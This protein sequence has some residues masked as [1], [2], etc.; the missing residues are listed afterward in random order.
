MATR[1]P[2]ELFQCP[3]CKAWYPH[4]D[5]YRHEAFDCP[6]RKERNDG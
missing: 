3:K 1:Q 6:K 2:G 5:G 4:D